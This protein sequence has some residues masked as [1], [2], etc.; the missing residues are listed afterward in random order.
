MKALK[1]VSGQISLCCCRLKLCHLLVGKFKLDYTPPGLNDEL[2]FCWGNRSTEILI[3]LTPRRA[4]PPPPY[5]ELRIKS[6]TK[7]QQAFCLRRLFP[8]KLKLL[9]ESMYAA[10]TFRKTV[11]CITLQSSWLGTLRR[12]LGWRSKEVNAPRW[13]KAEPLQSLPQTSQSRCVHFIFTF[14]LCKC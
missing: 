4:L 10:L 8:G 9:L 7:T 2:G 13:Q 14:S 5:V 6:G 1:V 3:T 12:G 11:L